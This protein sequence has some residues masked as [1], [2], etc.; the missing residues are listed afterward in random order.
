M[1]FREVTAKIKKSYTFKS[2]V[3]RPFKEQ[4]KKIFTVEPVSRRKKSNGC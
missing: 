2:I 4:Q 3:C 1:W